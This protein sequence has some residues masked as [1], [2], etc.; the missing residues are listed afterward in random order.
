MDATAIFELLQ[1]RHGAAV[2]SV[3]TDNPSPY[4]LVDK[5]AMAEVAATLKNDGALA[6]DFLQS[7]SGLDTGDK[8]VCVYH[9]FSYP[10][11]HAI[12]LK[13][14]IAYDD[15]KIASVVP[16]WPAANWLE[17]EQLDL[18]GIEF[19]GHPDPRR[20]MLPDD[21]VGHPLRKDYA[22]QSDYH[23]IETTRPNPLELLRQRDVAR[24]PASADKPSAS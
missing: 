11:R 18:F 17:R 15:T 5:S 20:I 3:V 22:P 16:Q 19:E 14:E 21:W 4:I 24:N 10:H 6:F 8:L 1:Q 2:L 9:L 12:V 23:G 7:V 13:A